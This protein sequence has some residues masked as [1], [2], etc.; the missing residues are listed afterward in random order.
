MNSQRKPQ[1]IVIRETEELEISIGDF[2]RKYKEEMFENITI[3]EIK[4]QDRFKDI[5]LFYKIL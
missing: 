2:R 1:E 3:K 5:H 4:V